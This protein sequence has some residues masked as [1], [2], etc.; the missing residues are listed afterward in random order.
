MT[1]RLGE[2]LSTQAKAKA[3]EPKG[4]G[5]ALEQPISEEAPR[6]KMTVPTKAP[7]SHAEA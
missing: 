4:S 1:M 5:G 7:A 3:S 2:V 6:P